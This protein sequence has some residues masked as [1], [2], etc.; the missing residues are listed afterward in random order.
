MK[1]YYLIIERLFYINLTIKV[2]LYL[3]KIKL[4]ENLSKEFNDFRYEN[5]LKL[6]SLLVNYN[7]FN[8]KCILI[9]IRYIFSF[10][11]SLII[12][13]MYTSCK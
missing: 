5:M 10:R 2:L 9:D 1:I 12:L 13:F 8:T 6:L 7:I 4:I 11:I 3:I